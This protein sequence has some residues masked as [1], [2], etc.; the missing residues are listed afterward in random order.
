MQRLCIPPLAVAC[1]V[2]ARSDVVVS[3]GE[4]ELYTLFSRKYLRYQ[5]AVFIF[6]V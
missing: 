6:S 1:A 2:E 5:H 3:G 4:Y